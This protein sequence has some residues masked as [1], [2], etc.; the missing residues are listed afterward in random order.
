MINQISSPM[1]FADDTNI[2][3]VH[4]NPNSFKEKIEEILLKIS[5]WFQ[6]NSLKL[7]LNKTN[8]F[9]FPQNLT[10]VLQSALTMNIT[11]LKTHKVQA[12]W[13]LF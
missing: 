4:H 3:Y 10:W 5:K 7:N 13:V 1:L 12:S 6:V 2:I 11:T 9:N 8:L